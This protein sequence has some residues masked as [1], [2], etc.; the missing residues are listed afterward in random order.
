[1]DQQ[2]DDLEKVQVQ[3]STL[4]QQNRAQ[5]AETV[6]LRKMI[7]MQHEQH[8]LGLAQL[9]QETNEKLNSM[10][11][12]AAA[13]VHHHRQQHSTN[14]ATIDS[15]LTMSP[16]SVGSSSIPQQQQQNHNLDSIDL[17][18]ASMTNRMDVM[19]T[20]FTIVQVMLAVMTLVYFWNTKRRYAFRV[21]S[22]STSSSSS[23][24]S[25]TPSSSSKTA[26]RVAKPTLL[27]DNSSDKSPT[28]SVTTNGN[29]KSNATTTTTTTA[30]TVSSPTSVCCTIAEPGLLFTEL[31]EQVV[32]YRAEVDEYK[33]KIAQL[34]LVQKK[35]RKD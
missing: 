24:I 30:V 26:N 13:Q 31:Q 19:T 9:A 3:F 34:L 15:L 7:E 10:V 29:C 28:C 16:S 14:T 18:V 35:L 2:R 12:E 25:P 17:M 4:F 27:L 11:F 1:M 32:Q 5:K 6:A 33:K 8:K 22:P 21:S 23:A 20:H